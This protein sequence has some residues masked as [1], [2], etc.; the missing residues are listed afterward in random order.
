MN[1]SIP[2]LCTLLTITSATI[3]ATLPDHL[4]EKKEEM[5]RRIKLGGINDSTFKNDDDEKLEVVKFHTYQDER[6][7]LM[8]RM[9]VTIEL[10]DKNDQTCF[11][12][13]MVPPRP[14]PTGY[15]GESDWEFQIP[16]GDM[17]RPKINAYAI[18]YGFIEDGT[19]VP[20][21]EDFDD[22]ESP[23][24]IVNR[25]DNRVEIFYTYNSHWY[26]D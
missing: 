9:R 17:K 24:E 15:T 20:V 19:F 4:A 21:A 16:H 7:D 26:R 10:I 2:L 18:Q 23:E 22:V 25:N 1:T 13:L 11:G 12:Q 14:Y 3:G 5:E 8:Y 6:D